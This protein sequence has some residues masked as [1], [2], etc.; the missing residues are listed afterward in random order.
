MVGPGFHVSNLPEI[1]DLGGLHDSIK[2]MNPNADVLNGIAY[3]HT[4]KKFYVTGKYWPQM[5]EIQF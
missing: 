2:R 5:F 1:K 3:N 4:T